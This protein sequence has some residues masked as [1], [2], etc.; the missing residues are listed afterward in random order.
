MARPPDSRR[1]SEGSASPKSAIS[2]RAWEIHSLVGRKKLRAMPYSTYKRDLSG[3]A[4]ESRIGFP[5]TRTE[6]KRNVVISCSRR[7]RHVISAASLDRRN[8]LPVF[9]VRHEVD[10]LRAPDELA[11]PLEIFVQVRFI[12]GDVQPLHCRRIVVAGLH[13]ALAADDAGQ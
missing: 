5:A 8:V 4:E 12:P 6:N 1:S 11:G 10:H 2:R 13:P 3:Y 7:L 9:L